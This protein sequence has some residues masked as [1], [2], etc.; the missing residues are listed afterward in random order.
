MLLTVTCAVL[1]DRADR[2]ERRPRPA[3]RKAV[4]PFAAGLIILASM[5]TWSVKYCC[6]S[7]V[8]RVFGPVTSI[9]GIWEEIGSN[10][11]D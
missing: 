5:F 3:V 11:A 6:G 1:L 4:L 7:D 8:L 2:G 10:V 9:T